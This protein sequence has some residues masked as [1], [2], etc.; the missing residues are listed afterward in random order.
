MR[1]RTMIWSL[2]IIVVSAMVLPAASYLLTGLGV[3]Q[4]QVT[5][6]NTNQRSNYWRAVREGNSGYS[7]VQGTDSTMRVINEE[8]STLFNIGGQNWRQQRN[9]QLANYGGW[10]LIISLFTL[11]MLYLYRGRVDVNKPLSGATVPRWSLIE[12][13]IHWYTAISFVILAIT[14]LSTIFGRVVLIPLLGA[15][16]F[17]W[18]ASV[19]MTL[20]NYIGPFF[21]IGVVLMLIFWIRHNIPRAGDLKWFTEGAGLKY[22]VHS[23]AD[24]ANPG[25]KIW[26][27]IVVLVGGVAVCVSGFVLDFP[28]W[29]Q[30]RADMQLAHL[31]HG[32][33]ALIWIAVFFGHVY[34]GTIGTE[35]ALEGMTTGRVSSEYAKQHHDIWYDKVKHLEEVTP[36][37]VSAG[38]V[39]SSSSSG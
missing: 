13:T 29:G 35:G 27:W 18:W 15:K 12:R 24:K 6:Q 30:T 39:P 37:T 3:A 11:T 28:I 2:V 21:S 22:D 19:S 23:S 25:E 16:G 9:G 14:G 26:F 10:L 36:R 1:S 4:A 38:A 32:A 34:L 5:D 17:A 20:H 33:G 8:T 7:A 31:V